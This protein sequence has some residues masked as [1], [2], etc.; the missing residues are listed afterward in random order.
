MNIYIYKFLSHFY[1]EILLRRM[2]DKGDLYG[3]T[4]GVYSVHHLLHANPLL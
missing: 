1:L 4:A 3:F 2:E